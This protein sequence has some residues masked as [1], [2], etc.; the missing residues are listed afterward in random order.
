MFLISGSQKL[1]SFV[2]E[3]PIFRS[4]GDV[5]QQIKKLVCSNANIS[6]DF[7]FSKLNRVGVRVILLNCLS[8]FGV[9]VLS[10]ARDKGMTGSGWAWVVT[11]GMTGSVSRHR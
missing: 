3:I 10:Q 1:F 5:I 2:F 4:A 7:F 11:D 9:Q 6:H 8:E